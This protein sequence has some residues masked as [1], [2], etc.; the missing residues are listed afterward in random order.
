MIK[1]HFNKEIVINKKGN[2]DF[3]NSTKCSICDNDYT[4][5]DIKV[6]DQCHIT[7]KYR[8]SSH[9]DYNINITSRHKI[10]VVSH[11]LKKDDSYLIIQ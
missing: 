9:R 3:G 6:R 10:P 5:N 1:N 7:G 2:E 8:D 11:N 4:D